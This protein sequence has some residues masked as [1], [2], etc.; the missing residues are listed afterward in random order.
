MKKVLMWYQKAFNKFILK[1][2]K[3]EKLS[4]IVEDLKVN[5]DQYLQDAI[6]A[7]KE[8]AGVVMHIPAHNEWV[9]QI[10]EIYKAAYGDELNLDNL[11][12]E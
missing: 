8:D 5:L 12:V 9:L 4:T 7:A 2:A 6:A 11:T 10:A 3:M 1:G